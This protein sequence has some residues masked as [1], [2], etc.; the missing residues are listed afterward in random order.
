MSS[1]TPQ[2]FLDDGGSFTKRIPRG[3][4]K[5]HVAKWISSAGSDTSGYTGS[6]I[7]DGADM[8]VPRGETPGFG[9]ID[10]RFYKQKKRKEGE[11][12]SRV[13]NGDVQKAIR[14]DIQR[15]MA[16][17]R[18]LG[19]VEAKKADSKNVYEKGSDGKEKKDTI[20]VPMPPQWGTFVI[21]ADDG[22]VIVIDKDGEFDS[23]PQK[24]VS[25]QPGR[26]VKAAST[27]APSSSSP[28]KHRTSTMKEQSKGKARKHKHRKSHPLP[29]PMKILTPIVESE[30]EDGYLPPDGKDMGS[31]TNFLM[32]G[33]A[34]G[35]PSRTGTSIVIPTSPASDGYDYI[36]P[37]SPIRSIS[38]MYRHVPAR[39]SSSP[40]Y[41]YVFPEEKSASPVRSPPG[42][43]PVSPTKS[44]SNVSWGDGGNAWGSE[45]SHRSGR[46]GKSHNSATGK[47]SVKSY[48]APTVEDAPNTSSD[49]KEKEDHH[50]DMWDGGVGHDK[51]TKS[52]TDSWVGGVDTSW[53]DPLKHIPM[54]SHSHPGSTTSAS[55]SW[56]SRVKAADNPS[57]TGIQASPQFGS[58]THGSPTRPS[59][60]ATWDGFERVKTMS[61]VSVVGSGS[62]RSKLGSQRSSRRSGT[63]RRSSRH[64]QSGWADSQANEKSSA[65]GNAEKTS[66]A[67]SQAS[68]KSQDQMSGWQGGSEQS[69]GSD[70]ARVDDDTWAG[71]QTGKDEGVSK[72]KNGFDEDDE[73][74]L[75]DNWGGIPVRVGRTARK[76]SVVGWE[77]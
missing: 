3:L 56:N 57:W 14:G 58:P 36:I 30:Y 19:G 39:T 35:W 45:R 11:G 65:H 40:A 67:G 51:P 8:H 43:W 16:K 76:E 55:R 32:T 68:H 27:I 53:H 5:R 25:E 10:T 22:R 38:E 37:V 44:S 7:D 69:W 29:S 63:S 20:T 2:S 47:A 21:K 50:A 66:W 62:E 49:E 71:S 75:N 9:T 42:S 52:H 33:G 74:Y 73:T 28:P 12:E 64:E 4:D 24:A 18:G 31:P 46:S 77:T 6:Y 34:S 41:E 70:K 17:I 54:H 48:K 23:G 60:E 59:S 72:Y 1:I 15:N 61:D 26:W 13:W